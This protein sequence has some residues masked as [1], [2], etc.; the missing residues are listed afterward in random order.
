[1]PAASSPQR[2][3]PETT[4]PTQNL[5][6]KAFVQAAEPDTLRV[7]NGDGGWFAKSGEVT[8][9]RPNGSKYFADLTHLLGVLASVGIRCCV[10]EWDGLEPQLDAGG[11]AAL[12]PGEYF[13]A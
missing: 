9:Q 12:A 6:L 7:L 4:M 5:Q 8:L 11:T 1:M 13:S 3:T 2:L 10:I